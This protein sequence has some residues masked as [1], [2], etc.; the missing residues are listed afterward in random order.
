MLNSCLRLDISLLSAWFSSLDS[1]P[2]YSAHW[3]CSCREGRME[4]GGQGPG[5]QDQGGSQDMEPLGFEYK[6]PPEEEWVEEEV[7]GGGP[8]RRWLCLGALT[9]L[10]IPGAVFAILHSSS[11]KTT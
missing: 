3:P 11:C 10:I 4:S 9:L 2:V 5:D 6:E 1:I 8:G 7:G